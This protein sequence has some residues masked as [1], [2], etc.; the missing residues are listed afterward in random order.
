MPDSDLEDRE[1]MRLSARG[2]RAAFGAIAA[3]HGP[4]VVRLA[5]AVLGDDAS[6]QDVAQDALLQGFR[7]AATFRPELGGV[8]PWLFA[9]ARHAAWHH[10]RGQSL[11]SD[12]GEA[13][14]QLGELGL[15]AGWSADDPE[16]MLARAEDAEALA[17]A[18]AGLSAKDRE[19]LL[20][21][22]V[23]GASGEETAAILELD[24]R[25]MKSR[26]H[27]ARLK[28]MSTLREGDT[29]MRAAQ[30]QE[31]GLDCAQVLERLSDY[32]DGHLGA[33]DK[34]AVDRHLQGCEVCERFGGRFKR[35]V[36][37]LR[38]QLGARPAVDADTYAALMA[39]WSHQPP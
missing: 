21:R 36:A 32:V 3:R 38:Q 12:P 2:D 20:L 26:L 34:A 25:S 35:T 31:G 13:E 39:R 17:W 19:V 37:G 11:A 6:A 8:R 14:P 28:L 10:R 7:R 22:D 33:E 16:S 24:L 23:E 18:L 29:A 4:A 30:R 27:R 15:S 5:R 1:L 9:I